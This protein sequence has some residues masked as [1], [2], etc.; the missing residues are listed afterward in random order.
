MASRTILGSFSVLQRRRHSPVVFTCT[1]PIV[2]RHQLSIKV[3]LLL[4]RHVAVS[5][6]T[7]VNNRKSTNES[8]IFSLINLHF[9]KYHLYIKNAII[10]KMPTCSL[11]NCTFSILVVYGRASMAALCLRKCWPKFTKI[12]RGCYST[13]P[14]T[15]PNFVKI[16]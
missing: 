10:S 1:K 15:N 14:L 11:K 5:Y 16:G 8:H 4:L 6:F 3:R 7:S 13:K 12:F 2:V 9:P